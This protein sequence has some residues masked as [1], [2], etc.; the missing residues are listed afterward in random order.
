MNVPPN[1]NLAASVKRVARVLACVALVF[2]SL[3]TF[4]AGVP[5]MMAL[6]LA[7]HTAIAVRDG[8]G[9]LPLAGCVLV[10]AVKR[11]DWPPGMWLLLGAILMVGLLETRVRRLTA[12]PQRQRL[13]W[14]LAV[15]LWLA[16]L[17]MAWDWH[18]GA[19][20]HHTAPPIDGRPIVCLG[21]SLTSYPPKGDYPAV[22]GSLLKVP[23]VNLGRPGITSKE[24]LTVLPELVKKRP[25]VVVIELG[26]HDFLKDQSFFKT[27]SREAT[28]RNL[29]R[30]ID[31]ARECRAEVVLVEIPR[32]FI[33]DPYA[34][35]ERELARQ[36]D[37]ELVADTA[38]R[39]LVLESPAGPIGVWTGG[40]Y[41]S[42]DGLHPNARGDAYLAQCIAAALVHIYGREILK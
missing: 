18:Q 11:V 30:F 40:P 12:G 29:E 37:L 8:N 17:E 23:V 14:V 31:A 3:L 21:D 24:A 38:I 4:P 27:A 20:A 34:G 9:W 36:Y 26:G 35:L 6:W 22:L 5:W 32:G 10:V 42:D 39:N 19:H 41:L 13:S 15:F 33:T 16:W 25:Q 28:R 1:N 7:L 2:G